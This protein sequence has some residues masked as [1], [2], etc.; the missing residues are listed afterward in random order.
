MDDSATIPRVQPKH[1]YRL[2][3][4]RDTLLVCTFTN[5]MQNTP[6]S[7]PQLKQQTLLCALHGGLMPKRTL[8]E[9]R[10]IDTWVG[11][12]PT[13]S[14]FM[15]WCSIKSAFCAMFAVSLVFFNIFFFSG[16]Q[17]EAIQ[18]PV[19]C[20]VARDHTQVYDTTWE[21]EPRGLPLGDATLTFFFL[22][23]NLAN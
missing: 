17:Y 16:C 22:L 9:Q 13:S 11:F 10:Q 3:T 6:H 20:R 5:I 2:A 21:A 12:E 8:L 23:N 14:G 7:I 19:N 4:V 1:I 15:C 18:L